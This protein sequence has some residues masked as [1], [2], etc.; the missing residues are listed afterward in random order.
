MSAI[1]GIFFPFKSAC[2][3]AFPVAAIAAE[4]LYA[5]SSQFCT[6]RTPSDDGFGVG[7]GGLAQLSQLGM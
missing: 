4:G 1:L 6:P 2:F 5:F 3:L 7:V